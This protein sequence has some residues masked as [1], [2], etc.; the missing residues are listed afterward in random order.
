MC[1]FLFFFFYAFHH[2]AGRAEAGLLAPRAPCHRLSLKRKPSHH[3]FHLHPH[4]SSIR[5]LQTHPGKKAPTHPAHPSTHAD[6]L[7]ALSPPPPPHSSSSSPSFWIRTAGGRSSGLSHLVVAPWTQAGSRNCK[8]FLSVASRGPMQRLS[9]FPS[10]LSSLKRCLLLHFSP[11]TEKG[12]ITRPPRPESAAHPLFSSSLYLSAVTGV[13]E[14]TKTCQSMHRTIRH[15]SCIPP[16]LLQPVIP[17]PPPTPRHFFVPQNSAVSVMCSFD[18]PAPP[19]SKPL[20]KK[21]T[22]CTS[23]VILV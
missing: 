23:V 5:H 1:N 19:Q 9:W 11:P 6:R 16:V 4:H 22:S 14:N 8:A 7:A 15:S 17:P 21:I 12:A 10:L 18:P 2:T 13:S 3:P 20:N